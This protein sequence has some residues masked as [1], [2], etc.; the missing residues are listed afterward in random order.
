MKVEKKKEESVEQAYRIHQQEVL[1]RYTRIGSILSLILM[2]AGVTLDYFVYPSLL[3]KLFGIRIMCDIVTAWILMVTY[4]SFGYRHILAL[5]F[6]MVLVANLSMSTMIYIS[7]GAISPYYAGLN[8]VILGVGVLIP[9]TTKETLGLCLS[10]LIMYLSACLFHRQTPIDWNILF[11][12]I[13]FIVLTATICVTAT[14]YISRR[15]FEEFR[16]RYELDIKNKELAESY[17]QL[18]ELDRLKSEFFANI[19]H[20][21]RTPLTLIISPIQ[22]L[23]HRKVRLPHE[24]REALNIALQNSIKLLKLI[25]DLL[26]I[27][28]FESGKA[29]IRLQP[30]NLSSFIPGIMDSI[31][32]LAHA[33]GLAI[34]TQGYERDLIIQGDFDRLEEAILNLLT[35]AI[36]FTPSGGSITTR[37]VRENGRA[38]VEVQDTGIGIPEKDLPRIFERFHQVDGSVTR[39]VQGLGI[40]LTL[41][42]NIVE[43]HGGCVRAYSKVGEGTTIRIELPLTS[44]IMTVTETSESEMAEKDSALELYH[45]PELLA[46]E[47]REDQTPYNAPVGTGDFT[48]LIVED[49]PDMRKFLV[50]T[51]ALE[52]RVLQAADG[53][54]GLE[55]VKKHRPD[56]VL[57]DLMLP[58]IDGLNICKAIKEDRATRNIKVVVL[59]ARVDEQAKISALERGADDFVTKPF[60]TTEIKVRLANLLRA[61]ELEDD[62]RKRNVELEN[63]L[64]RLKDT[65]GQLIQSEKMNALGNLAAG[66]IHEINNPLNF[67]LPALH[68]ARDEIGDSNPE[69]QK[70]YLI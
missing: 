10:T 7:E 62:L 32:H 61:A 16:L 17:E 18:E 67:T 56:L 15:R 33:K 20:E 30:V 65:E 5:G 31:R 36:K 11:N 43:E 21:L 46:G 49:E 40:G 60:S 59:T 25:N 9:W 53:E 55:M 23:L 28:R 54:T 3:L 8:L 4:T 41:A 44:D 45:V 70:R 34:Y 66:L 12:N 63:A 50:S 13:Y 26:D 39:R 19:S 37:W 57:L 42:K 14:Y 48:I 22:D 24:A 2:P 47:S 1:I 38:I 51:L 27:V 6:F 68:V 35:N 58:G 64:K 52:Y 29:K 69:I